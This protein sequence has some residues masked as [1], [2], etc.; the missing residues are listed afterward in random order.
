VIGAVIVVIV[1]AAF[2]YYEYRNHQITRVVVNGLAAQ[3]PSGVENLCSC[4]RLLAAT[5]STRT[6]YSGCV[7]R[8]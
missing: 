8:G 1:V 6:P 3:V 7:P 5:S 4:G 2:G